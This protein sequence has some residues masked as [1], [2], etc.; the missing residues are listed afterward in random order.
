MGRHAAIARLL[1]GPS[2]SGSLHQV[3]AM[4]ST[5]SDSATTQA[6]CPS[7]VHLTTSSS[8]EDV[9]KAGALE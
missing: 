2:L 6:T 3:L 4:G 7:N 5:Y 1:A 9:E 8:Q